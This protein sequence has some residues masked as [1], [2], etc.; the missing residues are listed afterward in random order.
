MLVERVEGFATHAQWQR[1]YQEINDFEKQLTEAKACVLKFWLHIDQ[2]EQLN[3][4][5]LRERT[6]YKKYKITEEDYRNR[7]KWKLY[8]QAANDMIE[9]T[10]SAAAP[11]YLIPANCKRFARVK[12][13]EAIC[14]EL[15]NALKKI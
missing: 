14:E 6:R 11:W 4:F 1:A 3:R 8:T 10:H 9:N 15:E 5:Q 2:D 13:L 7:E 12:I